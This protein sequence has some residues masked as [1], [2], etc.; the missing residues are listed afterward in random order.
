MRED[1]R[2][3]FALAP[4]F[5]S[6]FPR[7]VDLSP[8]PLG[9]CRGA[10]EAELRREHPMVIAGPWPPLAPVGGCKFGRGAPPTRPA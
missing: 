2:G 5:H 3:A 8:R 4:F 1:I 9:P 7:K 10:K 6:H